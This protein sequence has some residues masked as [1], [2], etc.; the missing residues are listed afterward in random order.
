MRS[1]H[2]DEVS[3]HQHSP[4]CGKLTTRASTQ[5]PGV[6]THSRGHETAS[7]RSQQA[8]RK[9]WQAGRE[10]RTFFPLVRSSTLTSCIL[11]SASK[12]VSLMSPGSCTRRQRLNA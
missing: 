4:P 8:L 7:S 11:F 1:Q 5:C 6:P 12:N 3:A 2:A 9:A 10:H